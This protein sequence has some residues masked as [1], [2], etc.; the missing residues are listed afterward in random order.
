MEDIGGI[1]G[2]ERCRTTA[3]DEI[4]Q[5]L[6][7]GLHDNPV[8]ESGNVP[9]VSC[10]VHMADEDSRLRLMSFMKKSF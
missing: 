5:K 9:H 10:G 3:A 6:A 1:H 7:V 2:S 8:A 4:F